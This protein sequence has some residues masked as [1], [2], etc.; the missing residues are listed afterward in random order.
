M[1]DRQRQRCTVRY[2]VGTYSGEEVVYC[3]DDD[4]TEDIERKARTQLRCR[5]LL[6]RSLSSAESRMAPPHPDV[7]SHAAPHR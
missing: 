7:P 6:L 3:W 4:L 1:N 2:Q 5:G